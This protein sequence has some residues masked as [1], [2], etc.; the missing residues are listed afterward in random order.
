M[1]VYVY[2]KGFDC[3]LSRALFI[4]PLLIIIEQ[5]LNLNLHSV[6]HKT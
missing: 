2:I 6:K 1:R 5:K 3:E 4:L